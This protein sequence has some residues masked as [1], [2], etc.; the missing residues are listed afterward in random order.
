VAAMAL[1]CR[2]DI[3][4]DAWREAR[5]HDSTRSCTSTMVEIPLAITAVIDCHAAHVFSG[6]TRIKQLEVKFYRRPIRTVRAIV[7]DNASLSVAT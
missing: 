7:G 6:R 5:A 3:G 1:V 2:L 4:V